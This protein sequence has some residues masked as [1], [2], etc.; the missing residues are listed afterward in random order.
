MYHGELVAFGAIVQ[1][2]LENRPEKE[3]N[4]AIKFCKSV[5]LPV[6][7]SGISNQELT[8]N[9]IMRVA[10]VACS[11]ENFMESEPFDVTPE[12]VVDAMIKTDH[13]GR[14]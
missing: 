2:V 14:K 13:L 5:G 4:E 10:K 11:P 6:S 7:L 3:I 8:T 12:M 1:L 9:D